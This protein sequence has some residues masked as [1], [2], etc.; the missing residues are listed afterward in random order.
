MRTPTRPY[1]IGPAS[2]TKAMMVQLDTPEPIASIKFDQPF[3]LHCIEI[4]T[5]NKRPLREVQI[6][7]KAGRTL[8]FVADVNMPGWY[9]IL[10][11]S[12]GELGCSCKKAQCKHREMLRQSDVAA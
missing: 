6:D 2:T 4:D 5:L 1:C 9:F 10:M 7:I 11:Y 3:T 12:N 8:Y